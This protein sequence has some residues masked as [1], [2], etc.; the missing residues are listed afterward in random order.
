VLVLSVILCLTQEPLP[1]EPLLAPIEEWDMK[2]IDSA[3]AITPEEECL[4][5]EE[6]AQGFF[7]GTRGYCEVDGEGIREGRCSKRS[8]GF[9]VEGM[10]P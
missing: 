10:T 3:R 4:P 1:L 5:N 8:R 2:V 7:P 6:V 9:T